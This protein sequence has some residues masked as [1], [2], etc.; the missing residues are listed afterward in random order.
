MGAGMAEVDA[1]TVGQRL[2]AQREKRG[3]SLTDI[4]ASTKISKAALLAIERDDIRQLPGGIFARSFVRSYAQALGL[5]PVATVDEFFA[6]FPPADADPLGTLGA[7]T[8]PASSISPG[9]RALLQFGVASIPLAIALVW[10]ALPA[11]RNPADRALSAD[12]VAAATADIPPP[13]ML[14][15]ASADIT[16]LHPEVVDA[17]HRTGVLNLVL[18]MKATCWVSATSDGHQI[19]ERLLNPGE[20]IELS[21]DRV[22]AFKVGDAGAVAMQINGEA[23][24]SL[25]GPGQVVTAR[26]DLS[27]FRNFLATP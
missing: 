15:P 22:V 8:A 12:R 16:I 6:Q 1:P 5:D 19:V 26:I 24:R 9:A 13:S 20:V 27:N 3:I 4:A 11:G 25:G 7:E 23:A 2:K 18:T 10:F 21:A 14:Q 17:S